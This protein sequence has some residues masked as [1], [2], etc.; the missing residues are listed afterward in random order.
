MGGPAS[1]AQAD[2]TGELS[3]PIKF[4]LQVGQLALSPV[5]NQA[6]FFQINQAGRIIAPVFQTFEAL[7]ENR[8]CAPRPDITDNS[9]HLANT[10][11]CYVQK[12]R[13]KIQDCST[14]S[15]HRDD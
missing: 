10:L 11:R 8:H 5:F 7:Q 9:T 1:M 3:Y 15:D 13:V 12:I 6:T 14:I 2:M 4:G